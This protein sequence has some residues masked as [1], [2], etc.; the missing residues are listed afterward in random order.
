VTL[1]RSGDSVISQN[2][3]GVTHQKGWNRDVYNTLVPFELQ[4]SKSKEMGFLFCKSMISA[5]GGRNG[6]NYEDYF[7]RRLDERVRQINDSV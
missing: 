1:I 4:D 2:K 6:G 3:V 7:K 5:I